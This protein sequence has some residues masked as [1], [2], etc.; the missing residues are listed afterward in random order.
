LHSKFESEESEAIKMLEMEQDM[1]KRLKQ[2][3]VVMA[4]SRKAGIETAA[5]RKVS[6][7]DGE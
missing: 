2:D 3:K 6:G 4:E 1:I 7:K 5:T